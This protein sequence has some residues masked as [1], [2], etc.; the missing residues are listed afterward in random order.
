MYIARRFAR[1]AQDGLHVI[2]QDGGNEYFFHLL[3]QGKRF[4]CFHL[5]QELGHDIA[6]FHPGEHRLRVG[7]AKLDAHQEKAKLRFRSHG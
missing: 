1:M 5:R 3:L 4:R 6:P 2:K 7:I